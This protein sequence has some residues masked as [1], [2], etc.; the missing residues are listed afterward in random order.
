M[1]DTS[2]ARNEDQ[3]AIYGRAEALGASAFTLSS[4]AGARAFVEAKDNATSS[5]TKSHHTFSLIS[6]YSDINNENVL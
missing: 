3:K 6:L 5:G 2:W 4:E 1:A